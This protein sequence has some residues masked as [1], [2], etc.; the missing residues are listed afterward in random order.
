[1]KRNSIKSEKFSIMQR[2]AACCVLLFAMAGSALAQ[3]SDG[4][5]VIKREGT[6]SN[7]HYLA[8][9]KDGD[10]Y[11]LQD[12]TSFSPNCLW[13]SGR[14]YNLA[15]TK[16]NYYFIDDDGDPRFLGAV[17][18]PQGDLFLSPAGTTPETYILNN[19]DT[20]YYFYDWDKDN[21]PIKDGGGVA[22]GRQYFVPDEDH[23]KYDWQDNECWKV[24]YIE[25]KNEGGYKWELS[26]SYHY[27]INDD[28]GA[29]FRTVKVTYHADK[30]ENESG[31]I[32]GFTD[33]YNLVWEANP[34]GV[35]LTGTVTDYSYD[36]TYDYKT[37]EFDEVTGHYSYPEPIPS[38]AIQH[39]SYDFCD[40]T[41]TLGEPSA[42][43][44]GPFSASTCTREWVI[45]DDPDEFLSFA[46]DEASDTTDVAS[47]KLYYRTQNTKG[48]RVVTV[49]LTVTFYEGGVVKTTQVRT[50]S[51]TVKTP[52]Q[53]PAQAAEPVISY[54]DVT[55]SWYPTAE[56]YKVYWR[57]SGASAWASEDVGTATSYAIPGLKA[58]TPYDYKVC[59]ICGDTEMAETEVYHFTTK[60]AGKVLVYGSVFGGGRMA[61]VVGNTEVVIINCD[62]IGAVFGG[63]DIAGEVQGA[64][65]SKITLGVNSGDTYASY[66]TTKADIGVRIGS[67][68]GGGNG[69]YAYNGSSFVGATSSTTSVP[70]NTSV[71]AQS[72]SGAWNVPVWTNESSS[73]ETLTIPTITKT[74]IIVRNDTVRVDSIFGGAKNAF[75]TYT[76]NENG[77]SI[78]VDGGTVYA[79]FGGNNYGGSQAG[80]KHYI[81]VNGTKTDLTPGVQSTA[82]TG[83]GCDFGI[84]YLFGGGNKVP[85]LETDIVIN[86]GQTDTIF[87]GG[88]S[89]D[90]QAA[91]VLVDCA[92]ASGSGVTFGKTYSNAIKSYSG[93]VIEIKNEADYTWNDTMG[94]YNVRTLFGGNNHAHMNILPQI[95]LSRGSVGTVY[96]GGNKGNMKKDQADDGTIASDFGSNYI[97]TT[98]L[99]INYGTHVV[100]NSAS[101]VVDNLYGGCQMSNVDYST[102]VE[103]K[104]GHVGSVYGGCNI[105]GD[106]GSKRTHLEASSPSEGYQAVKGATYVKVS[107]GTVHKNLFAGSNGYYHC[108]DGVFYIDG[109]INEGHY[110]GD[111][112]PTHNETHVIVSDKAWVKG[113]VYAG[114]N[115]ACVGFIEETARN[116]QPT[117]V[118]FATLKMTGGTV[119]VEGC[120]PTQGNVFGGGNMASIYGSNSVQVM[121]GKIH[122]A[123]Y[124]GNDQCGLVAQITNRVFPESAGYDVASDGNTSLTALGV[125]TYV[126]VTGKPQINTVYGGGNGAYDYTEENYCNPNDQPVQSNTFVDI[127]IDGT[128]DNPDTRGYIN[129]VYGGGNGVTVTGGITVMLNVDGGTTGVPKAYDHVGSIF[130][131]NNKGDLA[132][133]PDIVLLNGQVNTVYGGCNE[134]AMTGNFPVYNYDSTLVF[135]NMSSR[136][137]M[138]DKYRPMTTSGPG[139]AVQTHGVVSGRVFGGCRMNGN[140]IPNNTIVLVE[141]D[142]L[143]SGGTDYAEIYGGCDISGRVNGTSQVVV[144]ENGVACDV[145]GGGDGYY[146]YTSSEI[147][148]GVYVYE[149]R[150]IAT[151]AVVASSDTEITRPYSSESKVDMSGGQVCNIYAGSKAAT[152]GTSIVNLTGGIV[153]D[154]NYDD[155]IGNV[156]GGGKGIEA[157]GMEDAGLVTETTTVNITAGRVY[158][159][160]YGGGQLANVAGLATVNVSGG[161]IGNQLLNDALDGFDPEFNYAPENHKDYWNADS[162][163]LMNIGHVFGGGQGRFLADQ[164]ELM[165]LF[166]RVGR[167]E[168]N[169][170]PGA[171]LYGNVYGGGNLGKVEGQ[172]GHDYS[173]DVS[174]TGTVQR[175]AFGGG[176]GVMGD[177]DHQYDSIGDVVG[178]TRIQLHEGGKVQ[179]C[180]YGGGETANVEGDTYVILT[181]GEVG[182]RRTLEQILAQ[183][184]HCYVFGAG[185]GDPHA[186]NYNLWTNVNEAHLDISGHTRIYGSVVGGGEDGHVIDSIILN[187]HLES[188]A[189]SLGTHGYSGVDGNIFCGGRGFGAVAPTAGGVGGDIKAHVYGSGKILGNVYGGGRV[190]SVGINFDDETPEQGGDA[191]ESNE[192]GTVELTVDGDVI[193]GH[194]YVA[195][196]EDGKEYL[197]GDV[198]GN[199]FGAAKGVDMDPSEY[200]PD[201]DGDPTSNIPGT[202]IPNTTVQAIMGKVNNTIVTVGGNVLV[203]GS[204]Y[205]GGEMGRVMQNSSVSIQ[206]SA[207]IGELRPI[208]PDDPNFE[209]ESRKLQ[210]SGMVYGGSWGSYSAYAEWKDHPA[211]MSPTALGRTSVGRVYGNTTV[212]VGTLSASE[213]PTVRNNVYGGGAFASVGSYDPEHPADTVAKTGHTNITISNGIIGPFDHTGHNACVFGGGK[214]MYDAGNTTKSFGEVFHTHVTIEGPTDASKAWIEASVFGG[215]EDGDVVGNTQIDINGGKIGTTGITTWDGNIFGAGRN[216]HAGLGETVSHKAVGRVGG[217]VYINIRRVL[218]KGSVFGGGR[219]GSVGMLP[220]GTM[221]DDDDHGNIFVC[222]GIDKDGNHIQTGDIDI[223]HEYVGDHDPVGGNVYGGGKGSAGPP[224]SFFTTLAQV[225]E[226]NVF[227]G[228]ETGEETWIEGSVFG[229]GE[230]GHVLK[231]THVNIFGGLIGGLHYMPVGQDPQYC[232][233]VFH[234][235]VYGGGRGISK[236]ID[237]QGQEQY[238]PTAGMV[239]GNTF[240]TITGGRIVRNVYGGGNLG[241]VGNAEETPDPSGNYHTGQATVRISGGFIGG[242][243]NDNENFGNVF[244]SGHG[245]PGGVYAKLAYV[246]NT[247]V[248]IEG[249]AT[250]YGSVFGGGEDGHVRMNTLVD[251]QGGNIGKE[252]N[253]I[254]N[255]N[256][257]GGGRG[258][259]LDANGN[260][261]PTAGEVYGYTMVNVQKH[262]ST[263]AEPVIW[264]SVYGGGS[265]SVVHTYKQVNISAGEIHGNVYGGSR[266]IPSTRENK[267]PRTVNMWGGTV[268]GNIHGCSY[269]SV[270]GDLE[271]PAGSTWASF[272]N[273]SGGTVK[274]NVY[275]AGFGGYVKGS[276]AVLI[277]KNAIENAPEPIRSKNVH[278]PV[279]FEKGKLDI[280]GGVYA[281][282]NYFGAPHSGQTWRE[283]D[284]TGYS[285]V[286]VDGEGY[287]TTST[288]SNDANYMNIAG[289]LFG[290][291]THCESGALGRDIILRKYGT[292]T[293]TGSEMTAV[294]RSMPSIQ[295]VGNLILDE[296]NIQLTGARDIADHDNVETMYGMYI[297]DTALVVANGSAIVLGGNTE[298][299][300]IDSTFLVRSVKLNESESFYS[301][302][303]LRKGAGASVPYDL[304]FNYTWIG[305]NDDGTGPGELGGWDANLYLNGGTTALNRATEENVFLFNNASKLFVRYHIGQEN[306][307]GELQGFFRMK[308]PYYPKDLE[309][310]AYARKKITAG[311]SKDE[312]PVNTSDGGFVSY[313]ADYNYHTDNG[314]AYTKKKQHPYTNVKAMVT[315]KV[316]DYRMWNDAELPDHHRWYVDGINGTD[317]PAVDGFGRYPDKPKKTVFSILKETFPGPNC[318]YPDSC[319]I[320]V[321][322]PVLGSEEWARNAAHNDPF[323]N[324][325]ENGHLNFKYD[326]YTGEISDPEYQ[327]Q[328]VRYPGGH[329]M[330]DNT[331]Y[332]QGQGQGG[333]GP[334][335]GSLLI[336][337]HPTKTIYLRD[338]HLDGLGEYSSVDSVYH[339]INMNVDV[340][341]G[342]VKYNPANNNAPLVVINNNGKVRMSG[343]VLSSDPTRPG[344]R[345]DRGFNNIDASGTG[346]FYINSDYSGSDLNGGGVY[347][348]GTLQ[349]EGLVKVMN[350]K[351]KNGTGTINCNVYLPAFNKYME[352]T[353]ELDEASAIGVTN[354]IRNDE[355]SYTLNTFSPVAVANKNDEDNVDLAQDTWRKNCLIDDQQWFFGKGYFN[356]TNNVMEPK[357][358]YYAATITDYPSSPYPFGL[359]PN[360][361]LFHGWTW[362]SVVRVRPEGYISNTID[363]ISS[364]D[365]LAWLISL[366]NGANGQAAN[367]LTGKTLRLTGD[368][369]MNK[370]IWV[371]VGINSTRSFAGT[372]DGQGHLIKNLHIRYIGKGDTRYERNDY[373]LFG[374]V[375]SKGIVKRTFVTNGIID[376]SGAA[377]IGGLVGML[378]DGT[379]CES[380]SGATIKGNTTDCDGFYIG[381]LVGN[382]DVGELYSCISTVEI[383]AN[384]T[385]HDAIGG[386]VGRVGNSMA[387]KNSF[388]NVKF[389][390]AVAPTAAFGGL[391]G[392]NNGVIANCYMSLRDDLPDGLNHNNFGLLV[393]AT[394]AQPECIAN[395]FGQYINVASTNLEDAFTMSALGDGFCAPDCGRFSAVISSDTYGYMCSD[396]YIVDY[397]GERIDTTLFGKLNEYIETPAGKGGFGGNVKYARWARPTLSEINNDL[398]VLMMS[399]FGLTEGNL[400]KNKPGQGE[401]RSVGTYAGGTFLQYGGSIRDGN[402]LNTALGRTKANASND[403]LFVYGDITA[404]PTTPAG[405]FT[406][407][408]VAIYEHAS[409]LAPGTLASFDNTYVGVSFNNPCRSALDAYGQVLTRDWHMFSTPLRNAPLGIDYQG[410]NVNNNSNYVYNHWTGDKLPVF[411]FYSADVHDG[412]FPSKPEATTGLNGSYG[413]EYDFYCWFE[414][415]WQ[416]INFKRNGP[417]HWHYDFFGDHNHDHINYKAYFG[418]GEAPD[419]PE[420]VNEENLVLGKGYLMA[421]EADTYMQSHGYLNVA[422][423]TVKAQKSTQTYGVGGSYVGNNFLGNPFHTYLDFDVLKGGDNDLSGYYV[424]DATLGTSGGYLI[425]PPDAS[426]GGAYGSR[427]L[428]PHQGFFIQT[429]EVNKTVTFNPATPGLCVSRA[430]AASTTFRDAK[431]AFRLVNLYAYDSQGRADVVVVEFDRPD[432]GGGYKAKALRNSNHIIYAHH[433]DKDYGAFFAKQG[434]KRVP[435]WFRSYEEHEKQYTLRWDL[436]NGYFPKLYLVDNLTGVVCDM[437]TNDSYMFTASKNDY[438]SRFYITLENVDLEEY[439]DDELPKIFAFYDGSAWVITGKGRLELVDVTGRV[440]HAEDLRGEQSHVN[441]D[442]FAKGVYLLRLW[443]GNKARIQKII[444]Y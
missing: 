123:L 209:E 57:K 192:N 282:S 332:D 320:Y 172:S 215:G 221:V 146:N 135:N 167:T 132:I 232:N 122:G 274:G 125:H 392:V 28:I 118:G 97:G 96:G 239:R 67:V 108:N 142:I 41:N 61:N 53:S 441:F 308:S 397:L 339:E 152:T 34:D 202:F 144:L 234:G 323:G 42:Q 105:S 208:D 183:P 99:P 367:N 372:F 428:H 369:D 379:L 296:T 45:L 429:E 290:S 35:T 65:G 89:A 362:N 175:R 442:R 386:M 101:I 63:N 356:T 415:D 107:G 143:S 165:D 22:R 83:Y 382:G 139:T 338:V 84:R 424:Y 148:P 33:H 174:I 257:Y 98:Q 378:N 430:D 278:K 115:L 2:M 155:E 306:R 325:I 1:M 95:T 11:V 360:K 86:G 88:N 304:N 68:Y 236:Y 17:F 357:S 76:G 269:H 173:T 433:S 223:G 253:T 262:P 291:G 14:N 435:V 7:E 228:E 147:S 72:P 141:S 384:G 128:D 55:V 124:G 229:S 240:V 439:E 31:G 327:V 27:N 113:N 6:G 36:Y 264:N 343:E 179:V 342:G 189:D 277:G 102:W 206:G 178:N 410:Q 233:D 279:D 197:V 255:G 335:Y 70:A 219:M 16:H 235:N 25:L 409:I 75:L 8:H 353:D 319:V 111:S 32:T 131:G 149:V 85:G 313:T 355:D 15:G 407:S 226:T 245:A 322:G 116:F 414:P 365:G 413:Y 368:V 13:Y 82:T 154:D 114:G 164:A 351:Q 48:D 310:F 190:A 166:G 44:V 220:D 129:T 4:L 250:I 196:A 305:V 283:F 158:T 385:H 247:H 49:K 341:N 59:G 256:V 422:S 387:V 375:G 46:S 214:G 138:N 265:S 403:Y 354:P 287:N 408:K 168:V 340:V 294:S 333:I 285:K 238:S 157:E 18:V 298:S 213:R 268:D 271:A 30:K 252:G 371:P 307:Y 436:K 344:T 177:D 426:P 388:A 79:A 352:I 347:A 336:Q 359:D 185:K 329:L 444:L 376:P 187:F 20:S 280:Q 94:V 420:N 292:R 297:I 288:N 315:N 431:P 366:V 188:D 251:I 246:K 170:L 440:L 242:A 121:G 345:I 156:Y 222:V 47:P 321:V 427:F 358:T 103:V 80:G 87:G 225:R 243:N 194:E 90:V 69:Y 211:S 281:G 64:D 289:G 212:V 312:S 210:Y 254:F 437:T 207:Q 350:N 151:N 395:S 404:A 293:M 331:T 181:G 224:E 106:V 438:T 193:I 195:S 390:V 411:G 237:S 78:K 21:W 316:F 126:G 62:S 249:D 117:F 127:N 349:L 263:N 112:I 419:A 396:N 100:M 184:N 176:R 216:Y 133:L 191:G 54:E 406:Q 71:M 434:T 261:S 109:I 300:N 230:D 161:I 400:D 267:S 153:G 130:G 205:G 119:G 52:C 270:D 301:H 361:T 203:R 302:F 286:Y 405:E 182:R 137:C 180:L 104:E 51:V 311:G 334:Y 309:S 272:V 159:N 295:R 273:L 136:V 110:I 162:L 60:E 328:L 171:F 377:T 259:S 326:V 58:S 421:I 364:A 66:G 23:C 373:G 91:H 201:N 241:S 383:E 169:I 399:N 260:Y 231:D 74:S 266:E 389:D 19:S 317:D 120:G 324:P 198:G 200:D 275:G 3:G 186:G 9:V 145:Y 348:E 276:V 394:N 380:E 398:P 402:Q 73:A 24:F 204:V 160:V 337:D 40:S 418:V 12:A 81:E 244:G 416:W 56:S 10:D 217:N 150:D 163:I 284:I 92:L 218:L 318:F 391:A 38:S 363:T 258:L 5:F 50:A 134:G 26:D 346:N 425:Y 330:S 227:V 93:G 374:A 412:Y 432:N 248:I 314:A 39:F 37:Y 423:V 401:F 140:D 77:S 370:Y 443:K 199:V 29:K 417:S 299:A 43:H 303:F 381:G 393:G